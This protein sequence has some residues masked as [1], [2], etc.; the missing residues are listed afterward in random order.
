[1]KALN[2]IILAAILLALNAC[3]SAENS[4][5]D[6]DLNKQNCSVLYKGDKITFAFATK[7][8][9]AMMPT[10]L[11]ITGLKGEFS[12]LRVKISGVN[13]NMGVIEAPL[14]KRADA[15]ITNITISACVSQMRYKIELYADETPLNINAEFMM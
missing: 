15:Y 11:K 9:V 1:M 12:N 14:E 6:C 5:S 7:P 10:T 8:I 4:S 3:E 2:S 13:M